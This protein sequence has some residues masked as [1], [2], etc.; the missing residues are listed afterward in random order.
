MQQSLRVQSDNSVRP[1][2]QGRAANEAKLSLLLYLLY[3]KVVYGVYGSIII[4]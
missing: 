2:N 3:R 4:K 1:Q